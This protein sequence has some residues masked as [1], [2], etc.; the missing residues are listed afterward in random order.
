MNA[1]PP[2]R[3]TAIGTNE[4]DDDMAAALSLG[5]SF[6]VS[7]KVDSSTVDRALCGL[8]QC[9][10]RLR[11]RLQT[12][13]TVL[14]RQSTVISSMP[15]PARGIKLP[16]PSSEVDSRIASVEI[17][18]Q[19]I[20]LSETTQAYRTNLTPSEQRG[21]TK[22]LRSKD[23]LRYTV[24]DKCGSFVVMPQSMDKNI[25]NRA[26]SDSSTYCETTMAA[27]S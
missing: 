11:W 22:L 18:I 23:R 20:Y 15:S 7:P 17:A 14:D 24:G 2:K 8:H 3:F 26:L 12:G 6:A 9:A 19:R 25:T 21:I 4:V 27:F 13:P 10:H 16:K 1:V 5:P